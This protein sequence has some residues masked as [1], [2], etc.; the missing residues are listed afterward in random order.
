ME[1][2]EAWRGTLNQILYLTNYSRDLTAEDAASFAGRMI[3]Y[4]F[5][6]DGPAVYREALAQALAAPAVLSEQ[7]VPTPHTEATLREFLGKLAAELD[8]RKPWPSPHYR[9]LDVGQWATFGQARAIARIG[10]SPVSIGNHLRSLF[11]NV[12]VG[13]V[14]LPVLVFRIGS[15][16]VLALLGSADPKVHSVTLYQ[17][18]PGDPAQV[19]AHFCELTGFDPVEVERLSA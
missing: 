19:I 15:G 11:D 6:P 8:A 7:A 14:S 13:D 17:R 16:E 10:W 5:F 1:Y 4:D 18:D 12:Q 9:M 2:D 3:E